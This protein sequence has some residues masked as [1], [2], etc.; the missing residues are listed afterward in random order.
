MRSG[1]FK[2]IFE[3]QMHA[4]LRA[5][6]NGV[7]KANQICK[8]PCNTMRLRDEIQDAIASRAPTVPLSVSEGPWNVLFRTAKLHEFG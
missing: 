1:L 3:H 6:G 2:P 7:Q 5:G 8:Y 4:R